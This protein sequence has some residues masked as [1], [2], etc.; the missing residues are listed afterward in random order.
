MKK[1]LLPLLVLLLPLP[2]VAQ[3]QGLY[4]CIYDYTV[5]TPAEVSESYTTILQIGS[6]S[7]L[8]TDYAEYRVDS[9]TQAAAPD[10]AVMAA[11]KKLR[12]ETYY[13]DQAVEQGQPKGKMTLHS[14]IGL[15]YYSYAEPTGAMEWTFGDR[16]DTICGYLCQEAT[17]EY[18]GR[19]WT[20][21][22]APEIPVQYGP[23]KMNGLPGLILKATDSEGLHTFEAIQFRKA[24]GDMIAPHFPDAVKTKRKD[25]VRAKN[26]YEEDPLENIFSDSVTEIEV[27][28]NDAGDMSFVINGM[29][30]RVRPNGYV[31]LEL[32]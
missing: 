27:V 9:L 31:P 8:F 32:K 18:G 19:T 23:W 25:F 4:D 21:W 2:L 20:V 15:A 7:A 29:Q 5:Q 6:G 30:I 22:Y 14:A 13:F 10:E 3:E 17:T 26:D 28:K 24:E 1:I 12:D 16:T 11:T